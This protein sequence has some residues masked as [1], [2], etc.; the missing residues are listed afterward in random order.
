MIVEYELKNFL[1]KSIYQ[2]LFQW[3]LHFM[4]W[5]KLGLLTVLFGQKS[6]C[7]TKGS[8]AANPYC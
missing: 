8:G 3:E 4:L 7:H 6:D 2:T 5:Y 1:N